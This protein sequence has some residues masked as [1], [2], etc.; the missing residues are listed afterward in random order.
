MKKLFTLILGIALVYSCST[1][2]DGNGNSNTT[3]VPIAPSN[4]TGVV[5]ST[6][7]IN[8]TW[9]DNSTNETEFKIERKTGSENYAV[10][11]TTAADVTTFYD[12]GLTPST[13][14]SY[15][16]CSYNE[17][18]ISINYSNEFTQNTLSVII[19][20]SLNT[21]FATMI[22]NT[23][24][25][26]G[27]NITSDGGAPIIERGVVW[28]SCFNGAPNISLSTKT[29]D[30][31]GMGTFTSSITNLQ[32]NTQYAYCAYATNSAGTSYGEVFC[33][34]TKNFNISG[35]NITDIDGNTYQTTSNCGKNWT[36]SN[37]NV[38]RYRNGDVIPQITSAAQWGNYATTGAW[39]YYNYDPANAAIYGKLYNWF[40]VT[41]PRGLAPAGY[42][43]PSYTEW[44]TLIDCLGGANIAGGKLKEMGTTHW[45]SPNTGADNSS[46]LT[47]LPGGNVVISSSGIGNFGFFWS[48]S[49]GQGFNGNAAGIPFYI[50]YDNAKVT[51]SVGA[52][53]V[54]QYSVRCIKD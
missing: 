48:S 51:S 46:G 27:G 1:S 53:A 34:T 45:T 10:V 8:L 30:G 29:I 49:S 20:P 14:Y 12:T 2:S 6:T 16:V 31:T 26:S 42:H 19:L 17:A 43:I 52:G 18:G 54:N 25:I 15:R 21:T 47:C 9:T 22:T 38:S 40:A 7:Q 23:T 5:A 13:T 50:Q 11:G 3:V 44:G 4:L 28:G 33:F 39:C 24:A 37:L 41:D 32:P 35:P 36:T